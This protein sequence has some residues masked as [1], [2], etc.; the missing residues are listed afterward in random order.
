MLNLEQLEDE[1][2]EAQYEKAELFD[3]YHTNWDALITELKAARR[4][5]QERD[6]RDQDMAWEHDLAD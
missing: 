1:R 5:Q 6:E 3:F 4:D 2:A